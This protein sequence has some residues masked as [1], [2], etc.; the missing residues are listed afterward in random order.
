[1]DDLNALTSFN[2]NVAYCVGKATLHLAGMMFIQ[3]ANFTLMRRD[4]FLDHLKQGVK[5]D[6]WSALRN[7]PLHLQALF[8]DN[9]LRKAEDDIQKFE[10]SCHISEP[11]SGSRGLGHRRGNRFQPYGNPAQWRQTQ[12]NR[13]QQNQ[14]GTPQQT[15]APAWCVFGNRGSGWGRGWGASHSLKSPRGA[16]LFK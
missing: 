15:E 16:G 7:A 6:N 5:Q 8:P 4:S 11:T 1:M 14:Q 2:K 9:V 3:M 13:S 12:D 10:A